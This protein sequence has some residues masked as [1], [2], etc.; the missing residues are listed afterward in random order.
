MDTTGGNQTEIL[1]LQKEIDDAREGYGD[2]LADQNVF[3][4]LNISI[5]R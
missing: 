5:T 4:D 1:A 2:S 3:D